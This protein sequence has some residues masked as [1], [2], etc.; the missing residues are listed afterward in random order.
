MSELNPT[1]EDEMEYA[2]LVATLRK[3]AQDCLDMGITVG[4]KS[5]GWTCYSDAADVAAPYERRLVAA[6]ARVKELE[7]EKARLEEE[8]SLLAL[9][10]E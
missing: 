3:R 5:V 2:G 6:E 1:T 8:C 10:Y 7:E 9:P 4:T